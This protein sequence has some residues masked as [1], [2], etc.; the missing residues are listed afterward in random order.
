M[1]GISS[2][3]GKSPQRRNIGQECIEPHEGMVCAAGRGYKE[4][5]LSP[6]KSLIRMTK[7][8]FFT[9]RISLFRMTKKAFSLRLSLALATG[10]RR[11]GS[12]YVPCPLLGGYA[13]KSPAG[14]LGS[15]GLI[16]K[17]ISE[18]LFYRSSRTQTRF[19]LA[20]SEPY[21]TFSSGV[22][23]ITIGSQIQFLYTIYSI[24]IERRSRYRVTI[25][26]NI[27]CTH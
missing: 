3:R 13:Q 14:L 8:P 24:H 15:A 27:F 9:R 1:T 18:S 19:F 17:F 10:F 21:V 6:N 11:R 7:K 4:A 20:I 26:F 23:T 12:L 16:I 5:F 22:V 25:P 2:I